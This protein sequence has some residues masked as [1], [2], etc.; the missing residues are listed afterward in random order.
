MKRK[1]NIMLLAIRN[2]KASQR[3]NNS[4]VDS[5]TKLSEIQTK[6]K[7]QDDLVNLILHTLQENNLLNI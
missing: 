7:Q 5:E 3:K 6:I 4:N 2:D 1:G